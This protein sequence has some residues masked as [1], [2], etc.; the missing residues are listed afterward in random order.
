M[1]IGGCLS[2]G[3]RSVKFSYRRR[4]C[5]GDYALYVCAAAAAVYQRYRVPRCRLLPSGQAHRRPA[6]RT[7][8]SALSRFFLIL[9]SVTTILLEGHTWYA[10][11]HDKRNV[12]RFT[13]LLVA[14]RF[15]TK[16]RHFQY[17][18]IVCIQ[19]A[20]NPNPDTNIKT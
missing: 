5:N 16:T 14:N 2:N 20:R 19:R 6:Y 15:T 3:Q 18:S 1:T 7:T 4:R 9:P 12:T 17:R 10:R 13:H 11:S 8:W